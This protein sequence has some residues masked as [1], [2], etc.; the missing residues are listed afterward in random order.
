MLNSQTTF[1]MTLG[2]EKEIGLILSGKLGSKM[3]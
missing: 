1:L 3:P 2:L